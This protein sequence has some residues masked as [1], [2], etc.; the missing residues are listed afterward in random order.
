MGDAGPRT[1]EWAFQGPSPDPR[2]RRDLNSVCSV[3]SGEKTEEE[4]EGDEGADG[5]ADAGEKKDNEGVGE[6]VAEESSYREDV[7]GKVFEIHNPGP[8]D[9]AFEKPGDN[10]DADGGVERGKRSG[11]EGQEDGEGVGQGYQG[12]DGGEDPVYHKPVKKHLQALVP[13]GADEAERKKGDDDGGDN[14]GEDF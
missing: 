9:I 6:A 11:K 8:A 12:A 13:P 5:A 2:G 4:G 10:A 7:I 14:P 3:F 1:G